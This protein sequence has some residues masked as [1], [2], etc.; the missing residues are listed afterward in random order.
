MHRAA[1]G[2]LIASGTWALVLLVERLFALGIPVMPAMWAAAGAFVLIAIIGTAVGRVAPLQAAVAID[3]A[4]GLRERLSSAWA[5][6]ASPDPFAR[7]VIAD[8]ERAAG[9][10]HVPSHLRYRAPELWPWSAATVVVAVLLALFMP[11]LDLLA[12]DPNANDGIGRAQ[13]E[14][15]RAAIN[16]ELED[17]VNRIKEMAENNPAL[18]DLARELEALETPEHATLTPQDVRRDAVKKIDNVADKL[19]AQKED[20]QLGAVNDLQRTLSRLDPQ[21]GDNPVSEL[22]KALNNGDFKGARDA[23]EKMK[24]ELEEAAAKGDPAARAR[25]EQLQSQMQRLADQLAEL[26]DALYLRKELENKVGLTPEQAR[27]LAEALKKMD[28]KDIEK[29]LQAQLSNKNLTPEQIKELVKKV[30]QQ[31][32]ACKQCQKLCKCMS[33]AAQ[34]MQSCCK[35]G[36]SSADAQCASAALSDAMGQMSELEMSEQLMNELEAQLADLQSLRQ[37]VCQGNCCRNGSCQGPPGNR[38]GSQGPQY[39]RGI[40][41]NIG[42][43]RVAHDLQPTKAQTQQRPGSIIGQMLIDGPQQRGQ[44]TAEERSAVNAAQRDAQDAIDQNLVPR[45]YH[46]AVQRYFERLAGLM[47]PASAAAPAEEPSDDAAEDASEDAEP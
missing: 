23:L 9:R 31:Q 21:A 3:E 6:G 7:A 40:G 35:S 42:A 22:S 19:A 36:C 16:L 29:Q 46:T 44:A 41:A 32:K 11:Q 43:E 37:D 14:E 27:E 33:Q 28:P 15:E 10:V 39:G 5:M 8:A 18:D 24:Q 2:L 34:A 25:L 38:V 47:R 30:Q 13:A 45:Q 1:I 4:A 12:G 17:R 20:P 26:D